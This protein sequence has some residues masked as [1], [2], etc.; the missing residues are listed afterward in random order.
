MNVKTTTR[1]ALALL[2]CGIAGCGGL[3]GPQQARA[4]QSY[5]LLDGGVSGLA[6]A[7]DARPCLSLRVSTP[8]SAPGF[9]STRMAYTSQSPQLDY[10]AYHEWVDTPARMVASMMEARL[11]ASGL[12]GAVMTGSSD[13][14]T[15]LRLDSEVKSLRQDFSASGSTL[16][17]EIKASLVDVSSRSLLSS[18][19]F[20]YR[21][22]ADSAT[23]EAGVAAANRAA[24]HFLGDL[25]GFVAA[26]ISR[27]D[28]PGGL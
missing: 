25:T 11:D 2:V 20:S 5:L 27:F 14:R 9:G 21:E 28:C 12:L 3:P 24:D 22:P 4:K 13:I 26:A 19:T 6:P 18:A 7:G 23:P 1:L 15:N 16:A 8:A 10:F 17:L